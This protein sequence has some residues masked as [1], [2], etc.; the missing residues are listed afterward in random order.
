MTTS[1]EEWNG[2][3]RSEAAGDSSDG[4]KEWWRPEPRVQ[5]ESAGKRIRS[6]TELDGAERWGRDMRVVPQFLT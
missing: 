1:P 5:T 2:E 4:S 6:G 3:C